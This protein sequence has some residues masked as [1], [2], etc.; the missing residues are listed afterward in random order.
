[1]HPGDL[2]GGFSDFDMTWL[3]YCAGAAIVLEPQS[4]HGVGACGFLY[5]QQCL[6][7]LHHRLM[8]I[9]CVLSCAV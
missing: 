6:L 3:L 9:D 2:A 7:G 5:E 1:M 4:S 8:Y